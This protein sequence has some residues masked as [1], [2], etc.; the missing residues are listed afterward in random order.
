MKQNNTKQREQAAAKALYR[1][2]EFQYEPIRKYWKKHSPK[3]YKEGFEKADYMERIAR[4][5]AL[6][7][8]LKM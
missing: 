8:K 4:L 1:M 5:D 3:T 7:A 2:L 6:A